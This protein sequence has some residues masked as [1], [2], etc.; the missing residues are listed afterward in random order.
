MAL[1]SGADET[2]KLLQRGLSGERCDGWHAG[3][4][5]T[6]TQM[7]V[8]SFEHMPPTRSANS[9]RQLC[10]PSVIPC[11][12]TEILTHYYFFWPWMCT[13]VWWLYCIVQVIEFG[14]HQS[15]QS[16][17]LPDSRCTL[18]FCQ[19]LAAWSTLPAQ[20]SV[21]CLE[22]GGPNYYRKKLGD[23]QACEL[24]GRVILI[25]ANKTWARA[26]QIA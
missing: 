11:S 16:N 1:S 13:C 9:F 10:A 8:Y 22:N 14:Y 26:G 19:C 6:A 7:P 24:G 17:V 15:P 25:N 4:R 2:P 5:T 21:R 3:N 23:H 18:R 12:G 20:I